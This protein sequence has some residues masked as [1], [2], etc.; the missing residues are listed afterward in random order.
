MRTYHPLDPDVAQDPYPYYAEL[1]RDAPVYPIPGF[2]LWAVSRHADVL[3]VLRHPETFS[4]SA[5]RAALMR[6][7]TVSPDDPDHEPFKAETLIGSDP[8][9]H[10][11]LRK[12]ANR[13][14]TP[15]RV[16]ALEPRIREIARELLADFVA[17]G[18]CD[19]VADYAVPLPVRVIAELLGVDPERRHD[20]KRWSEAMV[21]AAFDSTE[22]EKPAVGQN[23]QEW[24]DY[25]DQVI[26][27]RRRDP[28]EDIISA[29]LQEEEPD[30]A[31]SPNEL[32]SLLGTLLAAGNVTTTNLIANA[33]VALLERPHQLALVQKDK[34][35]VPNLVEEA[36][37]YDSPVQLLPRTT[38]REVEIAGTKLPE[39]A[40][41]AILFASA[42]RDERVYAYPDRLDVMRDATG[43]LAFG[44][45]AHFCLGAPL[46]R[47]E[48][49]VAFEELFSRIREPALAQEAIRWKT[50]LVMRGPEN[51]YLCFERRSQ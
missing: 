24:S 33:T 18:E 2:G 36:L 22:E 14:F 46:A 38:T 6:A 20:F 1:R 49:R 23:L 48:A 25:F 34:G 26:A 50:S 47:L 13:G 9:V 39:G 11:R 29:L 17:K 5:M 51:L 35:L 10:N 40:G 16:A 4:S 42:N 41:L 3:H 19:L 21:S 43:H 31:L 7:E 28:Q 30:G 27:E 8:P 32:N 15:A 12:I 44:F 45:G 37:R